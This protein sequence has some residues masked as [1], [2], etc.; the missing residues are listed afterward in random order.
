MKTLLVIALGLLCS[1][2]QAQYAFYAQRSQSWTGYPGA[3]YVIVPFQTTRV[4]DGS[5]FDVASSKW[6]PP[7]GP[8]LLQA[9]LFISDSGGIPVNPSYV[10]K[11]IKNEWIDV[12]T[13]IGAAG[14]LWWTVV[15]QLSCSDRAQPG[16]YYRLAVAVSSLGPWTLDGN[17]AHTY[18]SGVALTKGP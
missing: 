11:L 9:Q 16:D 8:V 6:W 13:G 2:A 18:F 10:A 7:A 1:V 4:N 17:P 3:G 12:C 15:I 14:S 5:Y